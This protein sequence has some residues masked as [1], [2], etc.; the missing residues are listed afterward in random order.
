MTG[1]ERQV[2]KPAAELREM[3][4]AQGITPDKNVYTY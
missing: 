1:D 4:R 2:F 3:L